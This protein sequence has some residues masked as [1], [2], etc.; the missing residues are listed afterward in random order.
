MNRIKTILVD[1][2]PLAREG[3]RLLLA[4]DPQIIV[5]AEC[6]FGKHAILEIQEHKPDLLFLDVQMPEMNGF[7]VL[8]QLHKELYPT[9][10]FVT[11]Y[12][13]YALQAF[14]AEALDYLLKPFSDERFHKALQ[15]AKAKIAQNRAQG[16]NHHLVNLLSEYQLR[17][18]S[19]AITS[20]LEKLQIKVNGRYI[21]IDTDNIDWIEA[22]DYYVQIH[23]KDKAYLLRESIAQLEA[24]LNP[25]K[26][27][28]IHR[29]IIVNIAKVAELQFHR[30]G[31]SSVILHDGTKLKLSRRRREKTK[32]LMN[33]FSN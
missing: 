29:S 10:I 9:V 33:R 3:I 31:E 26:F 2:E 7:E 15:R 24:K 22:E 12:D 23:V 17:Q 5:I 20:F 13:Q 19:V 14:D 6:S 8:L 4:D 25:L 11:A 18:S 27:I 21:Y 16:D 1:D 32:A 30:L 28:R